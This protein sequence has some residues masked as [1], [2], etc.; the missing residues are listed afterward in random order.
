MAQLRLFANLREIAG[1][2]RIDIPAD[3]VGDLITAANGKFGADFEKGVETSRVWLNG[4]EASPADAVTPSDEVV[5][6]PPVSGGAQPATLVPSDLLGFLAVGVLLVAVFANTQGQEIWAASLVAIF[7]IWA[8]DVGAA[9]SSRGRTFAPLAV[10]A[11]SAAGALSA[12]ILGGAGYGLSVTAAVVIAL[13]WTVAFKSY[14]DVETF[15]PTLLVSLLA[16]L[17]SASLVLARSSFSPDERAVDV[18]LVATIVGV[19]L[20]TLVA[21][22]PAMPFVDPFSVT[23]IGAVLAAVAA[24]AFWDLEVV[25]YLLVGLALA[26]ALVAGQGLS[27]MLRTGR[28]ALTERPPGLLVSVDSIVLAAAVF[29]PLIRGIL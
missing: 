5:L 16:G 2:A 17:A 27:S 9:F 7:A 28:V 10:A 4:E 11:A 25:A 29:Y 15:A 8:L 3:T 24:A 23:A 1:T 19:G 22:M 12:H 13:G 6:L 20:G 26:V 14:R 21:R 18:F